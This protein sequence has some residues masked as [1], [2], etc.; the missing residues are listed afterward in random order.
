MA[1]LHTLEAIVKGQIHWHDVRRHF[2]PKHAASWTLHKHQAPSIAAPLLLMP[3][4]INQPWHSI[5]R[6]ER[7]AGWVFL[8]VG[9]SATAENA[10]LKSFLDKI[11]SDTTLSSPH[12]KLDEDLGS[13]HKEKWGMPAT[14]HLTRDLDAGIALL[15]TALMLTISEDMESFLYRMDNLPQQRQANLHNILTTWV[16]TAMTNGGNFFTPN[17]ELEDAIGADNKSVATAG[18]RSSDHTDEELLSAMDLEALH[19][20]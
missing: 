1:P 14:H 16:A 2:T 18:E 5:I 17:H 13:Q 12:H 8:T 9:P 7:N 4:R 11:A 10:Q 20:L 15:L 6:F 19:A 3:V